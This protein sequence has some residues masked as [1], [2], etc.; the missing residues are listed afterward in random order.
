MACVGSAALPEK[1]VR[2]HT[3]LQERKGRRSQHGFARCSAA[4]GSSFLAQQWDWTRS[5]GAGNLRVGGHYQ[6]HLVFLCAVLPSWAE[7][8]ASWFVS[9]SVAFVLQCEHKVLLPYS[10]SGRASAATDS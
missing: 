7:P 9:A 6:K 5:R 3:E 1:G 8:R 2:L 10:S 4:L